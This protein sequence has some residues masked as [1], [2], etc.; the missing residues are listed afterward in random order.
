MTTAHTADEVRTLLETGAAAADS[1]FE[2]AA[3]HLLTFT[4][5]LGRADLAA[6]I[7]TYIVAVDGREMPA[8]WI[9]DWAALGSL[10]DIGYLG[11]GDERLLKLAAGMAHG[12]PVDLR[13][14]RSARSATRTPVASWKPSPSA[15]VP[16]STARSLPRPP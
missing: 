7:E 13:A 12:T 10:E 1:R 6:Y 16:T 3:I 2:R 15:S 8:A 11:G 4:A 14:P 9:R 5:L